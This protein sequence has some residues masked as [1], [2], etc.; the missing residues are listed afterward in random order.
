MESQGRTVWIGIEGIGGS[1]KSTQMRRLRSALPFLYPDVSFHFEKEVS[2]NDVGSYLKSKIKG[3]DFRIKPSGSECN[4]ITD[5]LTISN[6]LTTIRELSVK[7]NNIVF[8]DRFILSDIA[9]ALTDGS[10]DL[11]SSLFCF[12]K[13]AFGNIYNHL[14]FNNSNNHTL[15]Y[16]YLDCPIEIACHRLAERNRLTIEDRHIEF[17]TK[18]TNSYKRLLL[19]QENAIIFNANTSMDKLH[20]EIIRK[21]ESIMNKFK[22]I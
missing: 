2:R 12:I 8:F 21:T 1:G 22:F 16:Y 5:L 13:E 10:V 14:A 15:F 11:D 17:L 6:R 19:S 9:H 3:N 4:I 20:M 7:T 18:L